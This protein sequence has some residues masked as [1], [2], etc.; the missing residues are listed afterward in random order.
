MS[1]ITLEK[2]RSSKALVHVSQITAVY[3][4]KWDEP[5]GLVRIA[6]AGDFMSPLMARESMAEVEEMLH[7]AGE[8]LHGL[9]R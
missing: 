8:T 6:L 3:Q 1:F 5:E 2:G 4:E 7:A 9:P